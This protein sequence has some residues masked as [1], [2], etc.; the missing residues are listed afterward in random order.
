MGL[1]EPHEHDS[2]L[3]SHIAEAEAL[4]RGFRDVGAFW[5]CDIGGLGRDKAFWGDDAAEEGWQ[6]HNPVQ[7]VSKDIHHEHGEVE[8]GSKDLRSKG[9][10]L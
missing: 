9:E 7:R 10:A 6:E 8:D 3:R 1:R 5:T 4:H 2:L